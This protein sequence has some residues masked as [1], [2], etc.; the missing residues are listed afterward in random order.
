MIEPA[1]AW[2][3]CPPRVYRDHWGFTVTVSG[4]MFL[5]VTHQAS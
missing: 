3:Y 2:T 1:P 5:G 4:K